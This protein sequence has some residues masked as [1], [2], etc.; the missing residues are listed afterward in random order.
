M[1][2]K[3]VWPTI[4]LMLTLFLISWY[5]DTQSSNKEQRNIVPLATDLNE[6]EQEIKKKLEILNADVATSSSLNETEAYNDILRLTEISTYKQAKAA[7][8]QTMS[9]HPHFVYLKWQKDNERVQVGSIPKISS[10]E[11]KAVLKETKQIIMHEQ[12]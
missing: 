11:G 12:K 3:W 5:M 9:E 2:K 4:S 1:K 10:E 8:Q 6:N 7:L